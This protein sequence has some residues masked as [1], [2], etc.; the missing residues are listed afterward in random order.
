MSFDSRARLP[1]V[2]I[3]LG[4]GVPSLAA[5]IYSMG[6]TGGPRAI[7]P[8]GLLAAR[9]GL[10][11]S[12]VLGLAGVIMAW[13]AGTTSVRLRLLLLAVAAALLLAM[14]AMFFV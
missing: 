12:A 7:P 11:L 9:L 1:Y 14:W 4:L 8:A 5:A 3:A 6:A 2:L 13:R 10:P